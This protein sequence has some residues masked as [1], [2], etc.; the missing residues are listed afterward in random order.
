MADEESGVGVSAPAT[1]PAESMVQ[2]MPQEE[3]RAPLRD[4]EHKEDMHDSSDSMPHD[5]EAGQDQDGKDVA[6][7]Y[8]KMSFIDLMVGITPDTLANFVL[9]KGE[10]LLKGGFLGAAG[11]VNKTLFAKASESERGDPDDLPKPPRRGRDV[12]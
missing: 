2:P 6:S 7:K 12:T 11:A 10:D 9:F 5:D 1:A 3:S 8:K 4:S